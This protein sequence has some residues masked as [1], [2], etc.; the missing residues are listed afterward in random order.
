MIRRVRLLALVAL[1]TA[2]ASAPSAAYAAP[3]GQLTWGVHITL[4]PSYFD[5]A[6][7]PGLVTPFMLLSALHDALVKPMPGHAASPSL[8]E[9]WTMS[10][11]G[12][13]YEFA[14]R[15][16]VKFHNGDAV[17]SEDVKFSFERYRGSAAGLLK[18]RVARVETPTP[19][20]VRIVLKQPWADFMTFYAS[21][22]TGASWIVPKRYVE[23]VG[24]EGFKKAPVGAG[25][26]KFVSFKPGVELTLEANEQ[27]WRKVPHRG[28]QGEKAV[29][30]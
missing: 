29:V 9:S 17:T 26:Y 24:D 23:K 25:P 14:L 7:T 16:G 15:R 3:E 20:R 8:A 4:V 19:E 12:L 6:E 28:P 22:A 11:D 2:A 30:P 13:V 5:P 18:A 21:P 1:L 27:Y 10:K